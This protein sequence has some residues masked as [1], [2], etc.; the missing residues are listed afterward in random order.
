MPLVNRAIMNTMCIHIVTEAGKF[1]LKSASDGKLTM[2]PGHQSSFPS[3]FRRRWTVR[4]ATASSLLILKPE[5]AVA[6]AKSAGLTGQAASIRMEWVHQIV[7]FEPLTSKR[8][9]RNNNLVCALPKHKIIFKNFKFSKMK[10]LTRKQSLSSFILFLFAG[11]VLTF[12]QSC[13]DPCL[14]DEELDTFIR[15]NLSVSFRQTMAQKFGGEVTVT[16][17]NSSKLYST[18]VRRVG[19]RIKGAGGLGEESSRQRDD[20]FIIPPGRSVDRVYGFD[21]GDIIRSAYM[22][23]TSLGV[24]EKE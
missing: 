19:F 20:G 16:F 6:T 22:I 3:P 17:S 21:L 7:A 5:A 8:R 14:E 18:T 13:G 11:L 2:R 24:C 1:H 12:C 4:A 10:F 9:Y 15:E 23:K